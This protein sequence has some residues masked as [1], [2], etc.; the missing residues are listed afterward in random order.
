MLLRS[1]PE[2]TPAQAKRRSMRLSFGVGCG[3]EFIFIDT[4]AE[5]ILDMRHHARARIDLS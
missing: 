1:D 2:R 3:G 4:D 5:S